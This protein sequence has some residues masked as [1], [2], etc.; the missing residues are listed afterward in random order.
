M[1]FLDNLP[2]FSFGVIIPN[3]CNLLYLIIDVRFITCYACFYCNY[4]EY[5]IF[6]INHVSMLYYIYDFI[7]I[8]IIIPHQISLWQIVDGSHPS[9][10]ICQKT[11]KM[12]IAYAFVN[13]MPNPWSMWGFE[14]GNGW[15]GEKGQILLLSF[16]ML[17]TNDL[18]GKKHM[19]ISAINHN[20]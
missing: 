12:H 7:L 2:D 10:P 5:F 17:M 11:K 14:G 15:V 16:L 18:S 20:F 3:A 6:I 1:K 8:H 13:G 4:S 19:N 9:W